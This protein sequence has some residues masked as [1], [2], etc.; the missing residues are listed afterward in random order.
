MLSPCRVK[1]TASGWACPGRM[2]SVI[3][4]SNTTVVTSLLCTEPILILVF[5]GPAATV[6][7]ETHRMEKRKDSLLS[8]SR[9]LG[10]CHHL[11]FLCLQN[12]PHRPGKDHR[13]RALRHLARIQHRVVARQRKIKLLHIPAKHIR[14]KDEFL[15]GVSTAGRRMRTFHACPP[16]NG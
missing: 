14:A 10:G 9:V 11:R 16:E 5:H 4:M 6:C 1:L 8:V 13:L 2:T 3:S 7:R 12:A 15:E